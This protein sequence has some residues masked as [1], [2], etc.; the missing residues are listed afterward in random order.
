MA[1]EKLENFFGDVNIPP[2]HFRG[3]NG[4]YTENL[5]KH[6]AGKKGLFEVNDGWYEI[7]GQEMTLD[8]SETDTQEKR[9][10]K[11][12]ELGHHVW[13]SF[14]PLKLKL[15]WKMK[16]LQFRLYG[17][18]EAFADQYA[19]MF[20]FQ[21]EYVPENKQF[22]DLMQDIFLFLEKSKSRQ[23]NSK[24]HRLLSYFLF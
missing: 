11:V 14:I 24:L 6:L 8:T 13:Y 20:G 9:H 12:H 17:V 1:K 4:V 10:S 22:D 2:H 19:S 16:C 7:L 3:L 23:P 15:R 5:N 21:K 18:R